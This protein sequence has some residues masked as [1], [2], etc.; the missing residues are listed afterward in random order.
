METLR[1]GHA[2]MLVLQGQQDIGLKLLVYAWD[3]AQHPISPLLV[4]D[5][6]SQIVVMVFM[7]IQSQENARIVH[8][9]VQLV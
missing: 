7:V 9:L 2:L 1:H 4:Q 3:S 8:Q 5:Y 6:A